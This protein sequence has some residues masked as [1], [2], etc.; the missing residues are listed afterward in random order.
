MKTLLALVLSATAGLASAQS[1][2][3]TQTPAPAAE[4]PAGGLNLNLNLNRDEL[5]KPSSSAA[6]QD[7]ASEKKSPDASGLPEMGGTPRQN[8]TIRSGSSNPFPKDM[9]PGMP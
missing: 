8:M 5:R 9:H 4:R 2:S 3:Q 1:Q 6:A 7:R